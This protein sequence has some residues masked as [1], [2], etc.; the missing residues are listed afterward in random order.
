M[1]RIIF[2]VDKICSDYRAGSNIAML[3]DC[4]KWCISGQSV[5]GLNYAYLLRDHPRKKT[6]GTKAGFPKG[7]KRIYRGKAIKEGE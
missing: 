4:Y 5:L 2:R 1:N 7:V 6:K 3:V